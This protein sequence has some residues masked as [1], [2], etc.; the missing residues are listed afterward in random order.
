MKHRAFIIACAIGALALAPL[1]LAF[2]LSGC[3]TVRPGSQSAEVRAEQVLAVSLAALDSFLRFESTHRSE[4]PPSVVT[5]ATAVRRDAPL[6]L[7]SAN[8][9]RM[10][11]KANREAG[12]ANL[13]TALAVVENLVGQIK[14]WAAPTTASGANFHRRH[15]LE[16]EQ[17]AIAAGT[18]TA[19]SWTVL[20]PLFAD[21]AREVYRSIRESRDAASQSAEWTSAED[22]SFSIKLASTLSLPHWKI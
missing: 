6:A 11:Y 21:L 20:V 19:G 8:T 17:E 2:L 14:V 15:S 10:A 22:A 3:A 13:W 16:L 7:S 5:I 12:A 18:L 4:L 1:P 9:I